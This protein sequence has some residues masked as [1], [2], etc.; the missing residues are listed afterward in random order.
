M[1]IYIPAKF[2]TGIY[3]GSTARYHRL[4]VTH[5]HNADAYLQCAE[6][7]MFDGWAG[8]SL[9]VGTTL[10]TSIAG[11]IGNLSD[12]SPST[13]C[14]FTM[15][16]AVI[17]YDHSA[18]QLLV[19]FSLTASLSHSGDDDETGAMPSEMELQAS[20]D[21]SNWT[22]IKT[23]TGISPWYR[24]EV[25]FFSVADTSLATAFAGKWR[26]QRTRAISTIGATDMLLAEWGIYDAVSDVALSSGGN[27]VSP[28]VSVGAVN[29]LLD[30]NFFTRCGMPLSRD[31]TNPPGA[32][33]GLDYGTVPKDQVAEVMMAAYAVTTVGMPTEFV[34][35]GSNWS[36]EFT[37]LA[38]FG[39]GT[40]ITW[41]TFQTQRFA[42]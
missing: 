22:T 1:T 13:D 5:T 3:P 30:G 16:S 40:P 12:N 26:T 11:A 15:P 18:A 37:E 14:R 39:D 20:S 41:S 4:V 28:V 33:F 17:G 29:A 27:I 35:E 36:G 31:K 7:T 21:G 10:G 23:Y 9:T 42:L 25:R 8:S 6:L 19:E 2:N 38:R 24:G 34:V 32:W